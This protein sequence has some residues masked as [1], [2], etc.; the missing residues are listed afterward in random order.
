MQKMRV[1]AWLL[2]VSTVL[3]VN[4]ST[5]LAQNFLEQQAAGENFY[6]I[7]EQWHHDHPDIESAAV[8][9]TTGSAPKHDYDADEIG[10]EREGENFLFARWE[11]Y[12]KNRVHDD[13]SFPSSQEIWNAW[14]NQQ[15]RNARSLKKRQ[16]S[17]MSAVAWKFLGPTSKVSS[18]RDAGVGRV[19]CVRFSPFNT[20][21]IWIGTPGGGLWLSP[22]AGESWIAKTD[23]FPSLGVADI[24]INPANSRELYLATGDM[25]G[26]NSMSFGVIKS[27]DAGTTWRQL[28]LSYLVSQTA[29]M[30][31]ILINPDNPSIILCGTS[32]GV[33]Y[34]SDAG[35]SWTKTVSGKVRDL[36][37]K[38]GNPSMVYASVGSTIYRSQNGGLQ[39]VKSSLPAGTP[40]AARIALAVTPANAEYIYALVSN[41]NNGFG[42]LCRSTNSGASW[43]IQSIGTP[44]TKN[45]LNWSSDGTY[46]PNATSQGQGWYDLSIAASPDDP[47]LILCGGVNIWRST[48]G[49]VDWII[50][51]H[52]Q[53][54]NAPFVHADCHDLSFLPLS[55]VGMVYACTDGGISVSE[56]SGVDW[57]DISAGLGI[58]QFYRIG[59][60]PANP[61]MVLGGC[62]DNGT[63]L[64]NNGAWRYVN[65]ADGMETFF[66]KSGQVAYSTIYYGDLYR[67]DN[68]GTSFR[69][70]VSPLA[71]N[72]GPWITAYMLNP[73]AQATLY[74]GTRLGV[75]KSIDRG[76]TWNAISTITQANAVSFAQSEADTSAFY[77]ATSNTIYK[78]TNGGATWTDVTGDVKHGF[79]S[80]LAADPTRAGVLAATISGYDSLRR[81]YLT[82]DAG[83]NWINVTKA[84]L[85]NVPVNCAAF[86][87]TG[88]LN[89]LIVGTDLG[90]YFTTDGSDAWE[91]LNNGLPTTIVNDIDVV[92]NT[93]HAGTFGRALWELSLP[94][95]KPIAEFSEST[96]E[97]C[98]GDYV[99]FNNESAGGNAV[100]QWTFNGGVPSQSGLSS[101]L[102]RYDS[103]GSFDVHFRVWNDC[104]S[105]S[106]TKMADVQVYDV[107]P[108]AIHRVDN[109][110]SVDAGQEYQWYRNGLAISG[111]TQSSY[112]TDSIGVFRVLVTDFH[113]CHVMSDSLVVGVLPVAWS[114][115]KQA[116][117]F[118]PNPA[119]N[120]LHIR[121]NAPV[122]RGLNLRIYDE[123]GSL[124]YQHQPAGQCASWQAD[125]DLR[126]ISSADYVLELS[127]DGTVY[128]QS[129]VKQ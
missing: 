105:D 81:V 94:G 76:N 89:M 10:E 1:F 97:I 116:L 125:L 106:V 55:G 88:C 67:S 77:T 123:R 117:E 28:S 71:S 129:F 118:Y 3:L 120:V 100:L 31:R 61:A 33:Y 30:S 23:S 49:G 15:A 8:Q 47:N 128:R 104:A 63:N 87:N 90:C 4:G 82:T 119:G 20:D 48:N 38:P 101:P 92:Q 108:A 50:S 16:N 59:T 66:E 64:Y 27:T 72:T 58:L 114:D 111:A 6:R 68:G 17:P 51:A 2:V 18:G 126:A 124:V 43:S 62:Q 11:E 79:I 103:S 85:P 70:T 121:W 60:N 42:A 34:S 54:T 110:L 80:R 37:F 12:W 69:T 13:G 22:D 65:F 21:S 56:N 14:K 99:Q 86:Y 112:T 35:E 102:V 78:T 115:Q 109:T 113:G 40:A 52:W 93:L 24:A 95:T 53:G 98:P 57:T 19:A 84:G 91:S 25:D 39:F 74:G 41:T 45:I 29:Q 9:S 75:Y 46:D 36:D 73:L 96:H 5:V 32:G 127:V 26:G 7:C 122:L 44:S 83:Q 107:H